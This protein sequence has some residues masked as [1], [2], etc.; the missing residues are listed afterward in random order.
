MIQWMARHKILTS[1]AVVL[2]IGSC[3]AQIAGAT[4]DDDASAK[5]SSVTQ[6]AEDP[7][8]ETASPSPTE[9]S[10]V[11]EPT[12]QE[13]WAAN[14]DMQ[15]SSYV[16]AV[17]AALS[18]RP[19]KVDGRSGSLNACRLLDKDL[20]LD[21][22]VARVQKSFSL[23]S[24]PTYDQALAV[25]ETTTTTICPEFTALHETQTSARAKRLRA[26]ERRRKAREE[27]RKKKEAQAAKAQAAKDRAAE[28]QAAEDRAALANVY[29]ANC[30]DVENAGAAPIYAGD[31]GYSRDLDR[32][33]DG[34]ACE[35]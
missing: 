5:E 17:A 4:K 8:S 1:L 33:G 20:G 19:K 31:P 16:V 30:T 6:T 14:Y 29:Y 9:E 32:D 23:T 13:I 11:P 24:A 25:L 26:E 34:V 2:L 7:T 15:E 21:R 18:L 28:A 27:L 35:Q 3:G 10:A 12:P 22:R